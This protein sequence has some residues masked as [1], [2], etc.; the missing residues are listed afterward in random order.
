MASNES[1]QMTKPTKRWLCPLSAMEVTEEVISRR[2]FSER[3][4][5]KVQ[6]RAS[7][8]KDS[9]ATKIRQSDGQKQVKSENIE[10]KRVL[11]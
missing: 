4:S 2:T 3:V 9:S 7:T 5:V 11:R 10:R 1:L 6:F 8:W